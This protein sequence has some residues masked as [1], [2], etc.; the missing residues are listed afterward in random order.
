MILDETLKN[1]DDPTHQ[2]TCQ[3]LCI[4]QT[5]MGQEA[6]GCCVQDSEKGCQW[7]LG[8]HVYDGKSGAVPVYDSN[9][10]PFKRQAMKCSPGKIL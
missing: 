6:W 3:R 2:E 10:Y 1:I 4:Q 7:D 9:G 5:A 8:Y